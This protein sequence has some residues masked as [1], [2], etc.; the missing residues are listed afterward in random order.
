[1]SDDD[2]DGFDP[3]TLPDPDKYRSSE[4]SDSDDVGNQI[5]DSKKQQGMRKRN[6]SDVEEAGPTSR[7]R[8]KTK[9]ETLEPLDTGL[10]LAEDEEL[11]L[12]LLKNQS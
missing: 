8:K 11:V 7:N 9:W 6:N 4:E 1:M 2:T 3:S 12:H 10:S 5:S